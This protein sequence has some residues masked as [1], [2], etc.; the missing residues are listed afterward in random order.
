MMRNK[1]N[2]IVFMVLWAIFLSLELI[3]SVP[4]RRLTLFHLQKLS[5]IPLGVFLV[6][7]P[8]VPKRWYAYFS[9][10]CLTPFIALFDYHIAGTSRHLGW[11]GEVTRYLLPA[12]III[13]VVTASTVAAWLRQIIQTG[14]QTLAR[15]ANKP[16]GE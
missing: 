5:L 6:A 4:P 13:A 11:T 10:L 2:T 7:L 12:L 1:R 16:D 15:N 3:A 14:I 8:K 9:A